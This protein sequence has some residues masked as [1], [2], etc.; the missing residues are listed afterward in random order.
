MPW[1][2]LVVMFSQGLTSQFSCHLKVGLSQQILLSPF[3]GLGSSEKGT[4]MTQTHVNNPV[5]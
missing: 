5:I 3:Q 1:Y 2:I 4:L